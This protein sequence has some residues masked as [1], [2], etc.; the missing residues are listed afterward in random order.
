[1]QTER[2]IE[3]MQIPCKNCMGPRRD[4]DGVYRKWYSPQFLPIATCDGEELWGIPLPVNTIGV[5]TGS[6]AIFAW[7]LHILYPPFSLHIVNF[8]LLKLLSSAFT[9]IFLSQL[10][11]TNFLHLFS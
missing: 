4:T 5:S 3:N 2:G 1:M 11:N 9:I 6:H 8:I 10:A 7:D